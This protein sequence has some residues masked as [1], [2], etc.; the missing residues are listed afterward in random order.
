MDGYVMIHR[1]LFDDHWVWGLKK[2]EPVTMGR[3]WIDLIQQA[4]FREES[5][6]MVRG[7][8]IPLAK[9][10]LIASRRFLEERWNWSNT[11]IEKFMKLLEKDAMITRKKRQ[12]ETVIT[13][14]NFGRYNNVFSGKTP[15]KRQRSARETPEK[16]HLDAKEKK[17]KK[18][19][20]EII[21][22]NDL[23]SSEPPK[24]SERRILEYEPVITELIEKFPEVEVRAEIEKAI[25]WL[26]SKGVR[27]KDYVAFARNWLRKKETSGTGQSAARTQSSISNRSAYDRIQK[28]FENGQH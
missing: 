9:G 16:R 21:L 4:C 20:K 17:E 28:R 14:C 1:S 25:D 5:K 13:L 6:R 19:N 26:K 12:G 10:E 2:N 23:E 3:A 22:S 15:Q 8:L 11:K 7:K 24:N 27:K 18:E